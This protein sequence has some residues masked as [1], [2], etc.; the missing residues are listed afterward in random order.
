MG[1]SRIPDAVLRRRPDDD[2][3]QRVPAIAVGRDDRRRL[4]GG[5][6]ASLSAARGEPD[7]SRRTTRRTSSTWTTAATKSSVASA[8]R[9][10]EQ[11][12]PQVAPLSRHDGESPRRTDTEGARPLR[13]ELEVTVK[14]RTGL[15]TFG[16]G[17]DDAEVRYLHSVVRR[18]LIDG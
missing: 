6:S 1:V 2:D 12:V 11:Q 7:H 10:A 13:R 5:F 16:A 15:T 3:R 18:A 4:E 9:A 8:T 14:T 17:L